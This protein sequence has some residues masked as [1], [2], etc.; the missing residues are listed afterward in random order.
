MFT[1]ILIPLDGSKTAEKVLPYARFLAGSLKLPVE[2]LAVV[3]I[4]EMATHMSADRARYLDTMIEDSVRNSE[5]YLRGV[6]GTFPGANTKCTVEKGKAEQVII[7][8][9]A[10]DKG[11]LITMATHGRSGINRWLLGS[12]AEKVLRGATNPLLLVRATDE[13]KADRVATLK[14]IVVPLDGSELA[15]SVLPTVVELAKILKLQVILFRAYS[16]PYSA[17]ASAEGYYAVDYEELLKAM[18]EEAAGY[19]EKKTEAVQELGIDKVSC[20]AKEGFAADEIISLSRKSP[21]NLIAMCTHGRSGV[22][23][24]V[25]GSVTETVVRHSADPVLVIRA[26]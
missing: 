19:L 23:R 4:V 6:A 11:T 12:I 1:R 13:A 10:A 25:L 16:I 18:R 24:W 20:V 17:Y 7:E 5:Q 15:E 8:T 2:L 14:S 21:D 3:D 9:A 22:K 26:S